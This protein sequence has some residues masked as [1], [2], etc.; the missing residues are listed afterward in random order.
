MAVKRAKEIAL[1][2]P[3]GPH[4]EVLITGVL[5]YAIDHECNWSYVTAPES[6]ALSVL[7][8]ILMVLQ[9]VTSGSLFFARRGFESVPDDVALAALGP[10][11]PGGTAA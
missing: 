4:Q 6:L 1:A 10:T 7:G 8:V 11:R 5:R 3:R 2:F 9:R